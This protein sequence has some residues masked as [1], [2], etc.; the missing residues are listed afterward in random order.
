[1]K[2]AIF[3]SY[4]SAMVFVLAVLFLFGQA[5]CVDS[6]L[7]VRGITGL[8]LWL[9]RL[10]LLPLTIVVF[11]GLIRRRLWAWKLGMVLLAIGVILLFI[12]PI[13]WYPSWQRM[14]A[15]DPASSDDA[16]MI[17]GYPA[18]AV[19]TRIVLGIWIAALITVILTFRQRVRLLR[20]IAQSTS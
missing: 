1:M 20:R 2:L 19:C 6:L 8:G 3:L 11:I 15:S 4:L 18:Y 7:S 13:E 9:L 17:K 10:L 12:H 5:F 14:K 16:G